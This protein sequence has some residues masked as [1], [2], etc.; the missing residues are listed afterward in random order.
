MKRAAEVG[1]NQF[2]LMCRSEMTNVTSMGHWM[3]A[4]GD[5]IRLLRGE[6]FGVSNSENGEGSGTGTRRRGRTRGDDG[7]ERGGGVWRGH[8][9]HCHHVYMRH[10]HDHSRGR[11]RPSR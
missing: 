10:P 5:D 3:E 9:L 4:S 7:G 2:R 11:P 6:R 8:R 1:L